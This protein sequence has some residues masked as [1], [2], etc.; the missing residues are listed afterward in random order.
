MVITDPALIRMETKLLKK[1]VFADADIKRGEEIYRLTG[2][3]LTL[4]QSNALGRNKNHTLQVGKNKY[5]Y[6]DAPGKYIRHSCNPNCGITAGMQLVA[7]RD[8][9]AGEE[10]NFDYSTTMLE[11]SWIMRCECGQPQCRGLIKDFDTLPKATQKKYIGLGIVQPFITEHLKQR[12][13]L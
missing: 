13:L 8:I 4:A 1:A 11:R 5:L 10:L 12:K 6:P 7:L 9:K 2:S 3:Y